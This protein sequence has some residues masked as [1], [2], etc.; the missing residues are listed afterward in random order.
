MK[1]PLVT[2]IKS[3]YRVILKTV[4]YITRTSKAIREKRTFRSQKSIN[5]SDDDE[6]PPAYI[7]NLISNRRAKFISF[8]LRGKFGFFCYAQKMDKPTSSVGCR[9]PP[10]FGFLF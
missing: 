8:N 4:S 7:E 1:Y 3:A 6:V 5:H 9:S 10:F 2:A